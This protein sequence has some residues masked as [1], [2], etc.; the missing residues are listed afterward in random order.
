[1]GIKKKANKMC[2]FGVRSACVPTA[3]RRAQTG[4]PIILAIPLIALPLDGVW[5]GVIKLMRNQNLI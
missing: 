4:C 5:V 3:I 2:V 1:L